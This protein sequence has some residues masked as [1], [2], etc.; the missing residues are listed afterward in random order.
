MCRMFFRIQWEYVFFLGAC[1]NTK[2]GGEGSGGGF[3]RKCEVGDKCDQITM[4]ETLK[5]LIE[6]P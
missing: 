4:R 6:N 1:Q 3:E 2:L 5:E